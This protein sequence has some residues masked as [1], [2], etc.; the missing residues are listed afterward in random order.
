MKKLKKIGAAVIAGVLCIHG[1]AFAA[2]YNREAEELNKLGL[3][4]GTENGF[5][6]ESPFTRAQGATMLVRIL[7]KEDEALS[8]PGQGIFE[9]VP[10][11]DWSEP[12][13]E[14]CFRNGITKG[15]GEKTFSPEEPMSGG[16]YI[17][18]VLRALGYQYAEP[19]NADLPAA[20]YGLLS[21]VTARGL[22][23]VKQL[24]RDRMVYISHRA[25][26][27]KMPDGRRLIEK[28]IDEK[29]VDGAVA[30][31]LGLLD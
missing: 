27:V 15:T 11:G 4:L 12:Y 20:E 10:D 28:L 9:D 17:T 13:V 16:E 6:L 14:Y 2:S 23:T 26:R 30:K 21:S 25:L 1:A 5:E 24:E 22:V 18:L 7:G 19:E 8:Q 31:S 29:A 3:F